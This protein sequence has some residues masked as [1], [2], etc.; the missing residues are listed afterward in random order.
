MNIVVTCGPS[1]EPIDQ[2]RRLTNF[3][4]GRLG[5]TLAEELSRRGARVF[6]YKGEMASFPGPREVHRVA[7]FSTNEV[8]RRQ[9]ETLAREEDIGIVFHVA[10]L[11]DFKVGHVETPEGVTLADN[12]ISTRDG[13]LHL[14]LVP[15]L[16]VLPEL[17]ALFARARVV[18]WKYELDGSRE[19]A[20]VRARRQLTTNGTAAC[21]LNGAAYGAGFAFCTPDGQYLHLPDRPALIR[22][23]ARWAGYPDPMA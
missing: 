21:V 18:G 16:K 22:H 4:T 17:R 23:L 13:A 8:L 7:S 12:K 6:C 20:L 15:T 14:V 1:H 11:C 19:D 3:S 9:L 5:V 2:A 10:A